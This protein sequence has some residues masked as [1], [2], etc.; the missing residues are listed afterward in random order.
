MPTQTPNHCPRDPLHS[1]CKA[2]STYRGSNTSRCSMISYFSFTIHDVAG[3]TVREKK[4]RNA[5]LDLIALLSCCSRKKKSCQQIKLR[6]NHSPEIFATPTATCYS[7]TP[8]CQDIEKFPKLF[9]HSPVH[10][11]VACQTLNQN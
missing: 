6:S 3:R 1:Y 10:E 7:Y 9:D 11:S 8:K 4:Q 2:D 5:Q